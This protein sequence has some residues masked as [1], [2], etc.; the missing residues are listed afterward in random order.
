[1]RLLLS[2]AAT[3]AVFALT[4]AIARATCSETCEVEITDIFCSPSSQ[5]TLTTRDPIYVHG[6]CTLTCCVPLNPEQP[7]GNCS[8]DATALWP[9]VLKIK[10]DDGKPVVGAFVATAQYC[11]SEELLAFD[12]TLDVGAYWVA[13]DNLLLVRFDVEDAVEDAPGGCSTRT[14]E[15]GTTGA[16]M[17]LAASVLVIRRRRRGVL[18]RAEF[19][20]GYIKSPRAA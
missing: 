20:F 18:P 1:M 14:G 19:Q 12:R 9:G 16:A 2:L 3:L 7:D 4:P 6:S 17:L 10:M 5:V 13:Q 11:E 15:A 8:T